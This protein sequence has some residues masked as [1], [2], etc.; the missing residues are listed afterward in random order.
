MKFRHEYKHYINRSDYYI[1]K[2]RLETIMKPDRNVNAE[3]KY[4]IRSL[5]FDNIYDKALREKIDGVNSREKFRFRYY[6]DDTSFIR[7]EKKSKIN[8]LCNKQSVKVSK[9]QVQKI[10][11]GD[12]EWMNTTEEKLLLELYSKIKGQL[13]IP[14]TIVEYIREPYTMEAGNVRI[15]IDSEIKTGILS[16]DFLNQDTYMVTAND[17]TMILEVKYDNYLPDVVRNIIALETR[18]S[19]AFSKYAV[20]RIYG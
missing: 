20:S 1:L 13:L 8:N 6:N 15:T 17:D 9:E 4:I 7:L 3:G 18:R 16:T 5:Y 10:I 11:D 19:S 12:Y 14:K 2:S